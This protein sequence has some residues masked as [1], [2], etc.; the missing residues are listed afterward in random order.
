MRSEGKTKT[1]E[2]KANFFDFTSSRKASPEDH[3]E[4]TNNSTSKALPASLESSI[5]DA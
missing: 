4:V 1:S 5:Q 3:S 2:S